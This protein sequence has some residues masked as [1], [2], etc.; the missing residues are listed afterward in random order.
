MNCSNK[1]CVYCDDEK[2][3]LDEIS[4]DELGVCRDLIL[5]NVN[6]EILKKEKAIILERWNDN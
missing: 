1:F 3:R 5:V 2:C 6:N 4:I